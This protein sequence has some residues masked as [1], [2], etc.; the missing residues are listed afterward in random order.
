MPLSNH[1]RYDAFG[2]NVAQTGSTTNEFLYRGEQWDSLL[3]MYYLRARYYWSQAGRFATVDQI[4]T[5]AASEQWNEIPL[6]RYAYASSSPVD[7][8]DPSGND[9]E[10][11]VALLEKQT[12][13]T[14][15][16]FL[17]SLAAT[18][19]TYCAINHC[20]RQKFSGRIQA[21]GEI[22]GDTPGG[23][24]RGKSVEWSQDIGPSAWQ[25][26]SML[27]ALYDQLSKPQQTAL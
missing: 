20:D 10:V 27:A 16:A 23:R 17:R 11:E 15:E 8:V 25:G 22:F 26:L 7:R 3:Q 12:A 21:Q 13:S 9:D 24:S 4:E 2:N 1:A 6:Q 14:I 19:L 5:I 18:G